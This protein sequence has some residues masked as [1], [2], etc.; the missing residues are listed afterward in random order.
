MGNK[1]VFQSPSLRKVKQLVVERNKTLDEAFHEVAGDVVGKYD[2]ERHSINEAMLINTRYL[3]QSIVT[4]ILQHFDKDRIGKITVEGLAKQMDT[5][6]K[7]R[8][9]ILNERKSRIL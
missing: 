6:Y 5:I 7:Q 4:K 2:P 3:S 9:G 8:R 1:L